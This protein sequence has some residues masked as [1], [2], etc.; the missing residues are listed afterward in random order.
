MGDWCS[1]DASTGVTCIKF[2]LPTSSS[3]ITM[4]P[5][6]KGRAS[7]RREMPFRRTGMPSEGESSLKV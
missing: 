3:I 1:A 4:F 2:Y 7:N 6:R 5:L